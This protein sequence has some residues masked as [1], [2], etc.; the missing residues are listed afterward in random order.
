MVHKIISIIENEKNFVWVIWFLLWILT[1]PGRS[2]LQ[3][4]L[5]DLFN[6][7]FLLLEVVNYIVYLFKVLDCGKVYG[8]NTSSKHVP[9][10]QVESYFENQS[11]LPWPLFSIHINWVLDSLWHRFLAINVSSKKPYNLGK[12]VFLLHDKWVQN[13][14]Q[15]NVG[16][17]SDLRNVTK[18][19]NI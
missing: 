1:T 5:V 6:I 9:E 14:S 10:L 3:V 13:G 2:S 4:F 12:Y 8:I 19:T 11:S 17:C 15:N 16:V 18:R 7:I